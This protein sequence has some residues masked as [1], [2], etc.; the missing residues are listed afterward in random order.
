LTQGK[1]LERD[2]ILLAGTPQRAAS[3][4]GIWKLL[5]NPVRHDQPSPNA[6][7]GDIAPPPSVNTVEL[8]N[9]ADDISETNN[10][11][12]AQ[13]DRVKAMRARLD[14][15]MKDAAPSLAGTSSKS[16]APQE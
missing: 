9:L 13:P 4:M 11:A 3:R 15:M 5:L 8:Y 6:L 16:G 7:A 2:A 1:A 12:T 10:L 14:A